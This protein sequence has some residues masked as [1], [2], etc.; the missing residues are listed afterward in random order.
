MPPEGEGQYLPR[1]R[2]EEVVVSH[3]I[4][5]TPTLILVD[6]YYPETSSSLTRERASIQGNLIIDPCPAGR[7][8]G[9]V[10][11]ADPD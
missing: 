11:F 6:N 9:C 4:Y 10:S 2:D 8:G 1:A 7:L 5:T 3:R